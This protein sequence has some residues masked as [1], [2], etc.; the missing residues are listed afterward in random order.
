VSSNKLS[1]R[2]MLKLLGTGVAG[3]YVTACVGSQPETSRSGAAVAEQ[4]QGV[5]P[6]AEPVTLQFMVYGGGD[7]KEREDAAVRAVYPDM[8]E[9]IKVDLVIGGSGDFE[10]AEK[11]RLALAAGQ[12]IPDMLDLAR[13]Q[14]VE[15]AAAG[16][17]L[18]V[19]NT[20]EPIKDNLY[21]G[22]IELVT[23]EGKF[24]GF[25]R[26]LKS[27]VYF[28]RA[29]L[30]EEAGI[31]V[32]DIV[33]VSDFIEAGKAFHAKVPDS[34]IW[35]LATQPNEYYLSMLTSAYP[36]ARYADPDGTYVVKENRAFRESFQFLK[37]I[38]D[39]EITLRVDDWSSDWEQAFADEAIC[40]AL[41][42]NWMKSFLPQFAP[43]QGGLW[44]AMLWPSLEPMAD[45]RYGWEGGGSI[46]IVPKRALH[47]QE[48][49]EY[50]TKMH[51]EKEGALAAFKATG[52]TP[53]MKSAQEEV[54]KLVRNAEKPESMSDEEWALQP[55]VY[56]GPEYQELEFTTY[57]FVKGFPYD[58]SSPKEI[59]IIMGWVT[60]Y[61]SDE[62]GL[63]EALAGAQADME[64]QI[65]NPY[66]I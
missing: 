3:L 21:L 66:D 20:Y 35:N 40:S 38:Y 7:R 26:S 61:L 2:E 39:S 41:I 13:S 49:V 55:N 53:L 27:K 37:D 29:D 16:E 60:K 56:F 10:V 54:M 15:F 25:P 50:L 19:S 36:D 24:I 32:D 30:F 42:A 18:D 4:P 63:D 52:L 11:L 9:R 17:L 62:V 33:T 64:S 47:P 12:D 22:V 44:K 14:T 23:Y 5:P 6:A 34:Y 48:A 65:G 8:A 58:P 51:L 43:E 59:E 57:D 28:Y 46:I 1:R 31:N 45:Q